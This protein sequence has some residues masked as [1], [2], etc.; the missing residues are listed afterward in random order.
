MSTK[1]NI[2]KPNIVKNDCRYGIKLKGL[3]TIYSE[4]V[5]AVLWLASVLLATC[6][7]LLTLRLH[8]SSKL[9]QL[10]IFGGS[11]AAAMNVSL[12]Y[13]ISFWTSQKA[14]VFVTKIAIVLKKLGF[15]FASKC[16]VS[17]KT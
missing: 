10:N 8:S 4:N 15:K 7:S 1:I 9:I 12:V 2:L 11:L 3:R 14:I 13:R 5:P 16:I 17:L 6:T